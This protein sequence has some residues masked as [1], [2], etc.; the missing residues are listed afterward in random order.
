MQILNNSLLF[1]AYYNVTLSKSVS[2]FC[3]D[4]NSLSL[5]KKLDV[6]EWHECHR[7]EY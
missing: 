2:V 7:R 1:L 3:I 5:D 4:K 6:S